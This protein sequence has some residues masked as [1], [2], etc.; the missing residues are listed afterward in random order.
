MSQSKE[1]PINNKWIKTAAGK[2]GTG[3][4]DL[5]ILTIPIN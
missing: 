3:I 1:E 5:R 4:A 2:P